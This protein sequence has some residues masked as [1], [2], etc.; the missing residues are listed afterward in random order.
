MTSSQQN[1]SSGLSLSDNMTSSWGAQDTLVPDEQFLDTVGSTDLCNLL[2]SL[3]V[4][5]TTIT[6]NYEER[7]FGSLGDSLEECCNEVFGVIWLLENGY[8][9]TKSGT[10]LLLA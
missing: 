10:E 9:L 8:L 1:P 5:V 6:T 7:S 3:G 4:V 2:D